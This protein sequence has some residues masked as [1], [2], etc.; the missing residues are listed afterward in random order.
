M[1]IFKAAKGEK[2]GYFAH[3][4]DNNTVFLIGVVPKINRHAIYLNIHYAA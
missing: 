1:G 2:E 3:Q 4:M